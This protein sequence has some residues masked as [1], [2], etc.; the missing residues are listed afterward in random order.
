V[1]VDWGIG[2]SCLQPEREKFRS[3]LEQ[4]SEKDSE[5]L[6]AFARADGDEFG[7]AQIGQHFDRVY[8]RRLTDKGL[9]IRTGRGRYKVYHPLFKLFLQGLKP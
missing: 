7:P 8:F 3:D 9:L 5:L 2:K 1:L 6:R 4:L